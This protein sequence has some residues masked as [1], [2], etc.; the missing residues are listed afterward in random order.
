MPVRELFRDDGIEFLNKR[1]NE[2]VTS[3][4]LPPQSGAW[5]TSYR[6]LR[7]RGSFDFSVLGVA[8]AARIV[9]GVV[10]EAHIVISGTGSRPLEAT[11]GAAALL[12]RRLDDGAAVAEA[13][14]RAARV[15]KP[16]DNT[17][18][19]LGWRKEMAHHY[20]ASA[21]ADLI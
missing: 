4:H 13:V 6:K 2:I 11:A 19:V 8:V 20:V 7:R 9:G 15:A 12:G 5:R 3:V 16:L 18:F 21:L 14:E 1:S 10:E 17:D